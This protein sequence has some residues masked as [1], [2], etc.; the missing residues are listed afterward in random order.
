MPRLELAGKTLGRLTFLHPTGRRKQGHVL[1]H[2]RCSC[3]CRFIL[4]A[5]VQQ[6]SCGCLKAETS[7]LNSMKHGHRRTDF[8]SPTWHSWRS[9]MKRC[10]QANRDIWW[11]SYWNRGIIVSKRWHKFENFLRDMGERPKGKTLDRIN[12]DGHYTPRNCR[13][14][15][16]R[17]QIANRRQ[18]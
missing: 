1:W 7:S 12:N 2:V 17:E 14:A 10:Y 4:G 15:T 3:G 18:P 8:T 9:M 6:K 16:P 5:G 11:D 13:W